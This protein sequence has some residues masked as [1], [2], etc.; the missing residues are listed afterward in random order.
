MEGR[1]IG[2]GFA[3]GLSVI[4]RPGCKNSFE[5]V[6]VFQKFAYICGIKNFAT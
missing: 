3:R 5:N 1:K 2:L 6:S 4:F